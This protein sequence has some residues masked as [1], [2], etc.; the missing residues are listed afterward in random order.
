MA[1]DMRCPD[2]DVHERHMLTMTFGGREVWC[3]GGPITAAPARVGWVDP[4]DEPG[5]PSD[6]S[7]KTWGLPDEWPDA[8][9][10]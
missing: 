7:I 10:Y 2:P 8:G 1:D 9:N 5:W 3:H 4:G 6:D